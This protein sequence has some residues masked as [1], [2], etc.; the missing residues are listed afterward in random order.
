MDDIEI[1]NQ[2]MDIA[3]AIM[4]NKGGE[5]DHLHESARKQGVI[6]DKQMCYEIGKSAILESEAELMH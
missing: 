4:K 1:H 5:F 3:K 2:C 6:L